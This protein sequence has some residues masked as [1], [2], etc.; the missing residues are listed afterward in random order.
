MSSEKIKRKKHHSFISYSTVQPLF[1]FSEKKEK[2]RNNIRP[3]TALTPISQKLS[4][5]S[6]ELPSLEF[7]SASISCNDRYFGENSKNLYYETYRQLKS[8]GEVLLGGFT[9][10]EQIVQISDEQNIFSQTVGS[11]E[12]FGV[13]TPPQTS[14]IELNNTEN[15]NN[16][17]IQTLENNDNNMSTINNTDS[18]VDESY[19]NFSNFITY[20]PE[21]PDLKLLAKKRHQINKND[22]NSCIQIKHVAEHYKNENHYTI[23]TA[24]NTNDENNNNNIID[25]IDNESHWSSIIDKNNNNNNTNNNNNNNVE[26]NSFLPLLNNNIPFSPFMNNKSSI[27]NNNN[28]NNNSST[29]LDTNNNNIISNNQTSYTC[30]SPRAIFLTGCLKKNLPPL[31]SALLRRKITPKID[32]SHMSIG[33]DLALVLSKC[34]YEIPKLHFLILRDNNLQSKSLTPLI[35]AISKRVDLEVLDLS[36]NKINLKVSHELKKYIGNNSCQLKT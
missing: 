1:T 5:F 22:K 29:L 23:T 10:L 25:N 2:F 15:K 16:E 7:G 18:N 8:R 3:K 36:Q 28:N 6:V 31:T 20:N 12:L 30:N 17:N 26:N 4:N 32:L 33:N 24:A 11:L 19:E 21:S 14:R 9:E 27:T 13:L 35:N 34:I